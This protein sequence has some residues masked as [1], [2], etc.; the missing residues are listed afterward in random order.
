[1]T[2]NAA[3]ESYAVLPTVRRLVD[4]A[5]IFSALSQPTHHGE[6]GTGEWLRAPLGSAVET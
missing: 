3:F 6:T 2:P 5:P 4:N 1:M